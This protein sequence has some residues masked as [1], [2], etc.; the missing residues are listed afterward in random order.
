MANVQIWIFLKN[1]K[2]EGVFL[3]LSTDSLLSPAS[4]IVSTGSLVQSVQELWP[5]ITSP[6]TVVSCE[7]V[8]GH[9][10][11]NL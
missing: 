7:G 1:L 4:R 11:S 10:L 6:V 2:C 8:K 3:P 9:C 5:I